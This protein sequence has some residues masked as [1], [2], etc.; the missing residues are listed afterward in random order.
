MTIRKPAPKVAVALIRAAFAMAKSSESALSVK[1]AYDLVAQLEGYKNWAHGKEHLTTSRNV[2]AK[3]KL[4]Y[5]SD[6]VKDWPVFVV[7]M[8]FDNEDNEELLYVMPEGST[9]QNRAMPRN[10]WEPFNEKGSVQMPVLF[11]LSDVKGRDA[12]RLS[13]FVVREVFARVPRIERYGVPSY[14]NEDGVAKWAVEDLGWNYLCYRNSDGASDSV[15]GTTAS[16]SGEDGSGRYWME[17]SV[18]P[19]VAQK[20]RVALAA[21]AVA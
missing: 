15:V 1:V 5:T 8:S 7:F 9:L 11:D 21:P 13:S 18:A 2:A 20:L 6:E 14:A 4:G 3:P 19:D 12:K 10:S 17:V 16:D